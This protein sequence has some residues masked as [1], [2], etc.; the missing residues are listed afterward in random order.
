MESKV[1]IKYDCSCEMMSICFEDKCLFYG[2]EWDFRRDAESLAKF[3]RSLKHEV[4][5]IE[6]DYE[7][8]EF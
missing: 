5:L 8:G 6:L 3:L 7:N 1:I 2:N 4:E